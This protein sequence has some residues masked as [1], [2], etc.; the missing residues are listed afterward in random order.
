MA[1]DYGDSQKGTDNANRLG[2]VR[3][4][5]GG[6]I[7]PQQMKKGMTVF[8]FLSLISGMVLLYLAFGFDFW[9]AA[10]F[11]FLGIGAIAAAI[12]YTVG[13]N[14]YGY[15]GY[16]D[17]F[18]FLFFGL[19]GVIGTYYLNA[20]QIDW[21]IWLPAISVGFLSTGVLN[22]NNMRDVEND[23]QSGKHTLVA[24]LGIRK[25]KLYHTFLII[26]AILSAGT[27]VL[28]NYSSIWNF[29]FLLPTILIVKDLKSVVYEKENVKLDP[30]L[31]KLAISTLLFVVFFGIGL[32]L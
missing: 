5:Q 3:T 26:G 32:L 8:V 27:Y 17:L 13:K 29:L 16:G 25:A 18:V 24:G 4:V 15:S 9:K 7:S 19:A 11:F 21:E 23:I 2:P 20:K 30:F 14:A 28:L 12:K 10:F 22:L 6:E 1:N 31:K